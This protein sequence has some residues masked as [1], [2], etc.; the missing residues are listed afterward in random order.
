MLITVGVNEGTEP[1]SYDVTFNPANETE[2]AV[3]TGYC[4][5]AGAPT[6][7]GNLTDGSVR[8]KPCRGLPKDGR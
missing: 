7:R 3:E 5:Y 6:H 4:R 2:T 1:T 8:Q